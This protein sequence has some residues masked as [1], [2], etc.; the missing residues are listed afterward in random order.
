MCREF[1]EALCSRAPSNGGWHRAPDR[2]HGCS[3]EGALRRRR[4]DRRTGQAV[5]RRTFFSKT[6]CRA[7]VAETLGRRPTGCRRHGL[8]PVPAAAPAQARWRCGSGFACASG[9]DSRGASARRWPGTVTVSVGKGP[10]WL[11]GSAKRH[12]RFP[13]A[14]VSRRRE[15]GFEPIPGALAPDGKSAIT[16]Q[17]E[18]DP[19]VASRQRIAFMPA[20]VPVQS[21]LSK[22]AR[23]H[24]H[25][26]ASLYKSS[27]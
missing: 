15:P 6:V 3:A 2:E 11:R 18:S 26:E 24:R 19:A 12:F 4:N 14:Q 21:P 17:S 9:P 1:F 8:T 27:T 22:S 13:G 10:G 25:D 7:V 16:T 23:F 20:G 5:L